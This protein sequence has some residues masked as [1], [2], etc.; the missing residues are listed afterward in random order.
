MVSVDDVDRTNR[1][2]VVGVGELPSVLALAMQLPGTA[3]TFW[4]LAYTEC[5]AG[6]VVL[7]AVEER[8][9]AQGAETEAGVAEQLL[10]VERHDYDRVRASLLV[11][12]ADATAF[13][14]R[15]RMAS[16]AKSEAI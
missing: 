6:V 3:S 14:R 4:H 5:A 9:R 11:G 12:V 2:F 8:D 10:V 13:S 7:G 15:A 16:S 1:Q